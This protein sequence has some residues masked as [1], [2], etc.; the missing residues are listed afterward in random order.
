MSFS[1]V[2]LLFTAYSVIG[3]ISEVIYCSFLERRFI[4]RGFLHGP[5][6]PV[7]GFGG[8][9]V[10]F[11]LEPWKDTWVLLFFAGMTV[12]SIL[13]YATSWILEQIFN[14]K[15]WDYSDMKFNLHGRVCLLNSV[16]FGLM[17]VLAVHFVHPKIM[18]IVMSFPEKTASIIASCIACV[19]AAD[20]LVT[21]RRLVSFG[22]QMAKFQEFCESLK[23]RYEAKEWFPK[24]QKISDIF[25]ELK[26][27]AEADKS[28]FNAKLLERLESF[29]ARHPASES[30]MH[31]FPTM[32]SKKYAGQFEYIRSEMLRRRLQKKAERAAAK[33]NKK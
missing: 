33:Q 13:E 22:E 17:G 3:W 27:R 7:Y 24:A 31:R 30:F 14:T 25:A 19:F 28:Q 9:L 4:N 2:F 6:C 20:G 23:E 1:Y 21:I 32:S 16:L 18:K 15:W 8:L 11:L 12:T 26:T 29:S 5:V 10:I